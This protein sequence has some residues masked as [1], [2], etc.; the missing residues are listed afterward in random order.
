MKDELSQA[1]LVPA[2]IKVSF[3]DSQD[4]SMNDSPMASK[5]TASSSEEGANSARITSGGSKIK[6]W[7]SKVLTKLH[8]KGREDEQS[9]QDQDF[10]S[11]TIKMT[12]G[13]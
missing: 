8:L 5:T 1:F 7:F 12:T 2:P 11:D 4:P 10:F 6:K 9:G 3:D 13:L